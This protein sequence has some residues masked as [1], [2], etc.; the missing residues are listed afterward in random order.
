MGGGSWK[1]RGLVPEQRL[2]ASHFGKTV[3]PPLGSVSSWVAHEL[4][5]TSLDV[6]LTGKGY[7]DIV[8]FILF[9]FLYS[10]KNFTV[11]FWDLQS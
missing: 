8:G 11:A 5:T 4:S 9:Y 2:N 10:W 1:G 6:I 7:L 3:R